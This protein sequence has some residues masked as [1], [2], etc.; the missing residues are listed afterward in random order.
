MIRCSPRLL[1][2][3]GGRVLEL[4]V[5]DYIV[6]FYS[7]LGEAML[8]GWASRYMSLLDPRTSRGKRQMGDIKIVTSKR[9]E[10]QPYNK[11]RSQ[12]KTE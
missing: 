4:D 5:F 12:R 3:R 7:F 9:V 8:L 6:L 10:L 2:S 1:A 11:S